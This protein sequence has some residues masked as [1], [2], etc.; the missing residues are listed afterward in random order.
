MGG[1]VDVIT[2]QRLE[3]VLIA[4]DGYRDVP[5]IGGEVFHL[6]AVDQFLSFQHAAEQQADNHQYD[7]DF[8][9]GKAGLIAFHYGTLLINGCGCYAEEFSK[10]RANVAPGF[11]FITALSKKLK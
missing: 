4:V 11:G 10:S 8:D 2:W 9:Q 5:E 1:N 3:L 6:G 7:G